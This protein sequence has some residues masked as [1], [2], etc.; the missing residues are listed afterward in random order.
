MFIYIIH[1]YIYIDMQNK[2]ARLE[3]QPPEKAFLWLKLGLSFVLAFFTNTGFLGRQQ[4]F[5]QATLR[6]HRDEQ[7]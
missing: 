3:T 2:A 6:D 7:Q 4:P 1:I 5:T